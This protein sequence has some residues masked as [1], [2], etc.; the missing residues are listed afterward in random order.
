MEPSIFKLEVKQKE[1]W[2]RV[3]KERKYMT[4]KTYMGP[5]ILKINLLRILLKKINK[6]AYSCQDMDKIN[7]RRISNLYNKMLFNHLFRNHQE[8]LIGLNFT[9]MLDFR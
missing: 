7:K 1:N 5:K 8:S 6:L 3:E 2:E 9:L 4:L